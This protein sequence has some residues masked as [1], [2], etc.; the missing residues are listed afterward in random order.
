MKFTMMLSSGLVS[1]LLA[2]P[3]FATVTSIATRGAGAADLDVLI[4]ADDAL[5]GLI[6]TELPGDNGWH[7]A[8]PASGDPANPN[9][10]PAFTDDD[11]FLSGLTGLLNDFPTVGSPTKLLQ[12]DLAAPT[13]IEKIGILSGNLSNADGRIFSTT[14]IPITA[15]VR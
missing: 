4:A 9:G 2:S 10:L 8:N 6:A 11:S 1:V 14:V 5:S 15:P 12:Y 13:D 3:T 7:P